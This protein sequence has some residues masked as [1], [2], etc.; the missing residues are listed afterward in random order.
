MIKF[1]VPVLAI[2]FVSCSTTYPNQKINGL[3]FP[4]VSGKSLTDSTYSIPSDMKGEPVLF[5][6]GYKQNSQFDIDRWLIGLD[7]KNQKMPTY[8]L[9]TIQ[10]MFPKMFSTKIDQGMRK[11]IP[12]VLWKSVITIYDDGEKIQQFT[13]NQNPNNTRVTLLNAKGVIIYFNDQGFSVEGLNELIEA[14]HSS[15]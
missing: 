5:L 12:K 11:G 13:G 1:F 9:P 7:M 4:N 3:N 6:I 14:Y 10:G 2:L 8:E 15:K